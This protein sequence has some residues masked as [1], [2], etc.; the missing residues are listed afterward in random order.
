[1]I[2][3]KLDSD[4]IILG[5]SEENVK[6]LKQDQPIRVQLSELG[7]KGEV[8]I[9]YGKTELDMQKQLREVGLISKDT[10]IKIDPRLE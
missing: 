8:F 2:K 4:K 9:I 6:R 5:L 7:L 1:M 3:A 10:E